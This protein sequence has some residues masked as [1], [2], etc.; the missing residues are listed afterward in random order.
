MLYYLLF[1]GGATIRAFDRCFMFSVSVKQ[2]LKMLPDQ[3]SIHDRTKANPHTHI[4]IHTCARAVLWV[5]D[6]VWRRRWLS[7]FTPA[8]SRSRPQTV[9]CVHVLQEADHFQV[10]QVD[11]IPDPSSSCLQGLPLSQTT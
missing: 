7:L 5:S 1:G 4:H 11:D 8:A 3:I 9:L 6:D 10:W 2:F